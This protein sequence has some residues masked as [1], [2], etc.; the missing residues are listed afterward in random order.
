MGFG[1]DI[2]VEVPERIV[3]TLRRAVGENGFD[4]ASVLDELDEL[5]ELDDEGLDD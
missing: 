2:V 5:D 4:V 1:D 3:A